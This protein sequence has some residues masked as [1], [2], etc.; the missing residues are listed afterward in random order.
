M[1][2][3]HTH[4]RIRIGIVAAVIFLT[5]A[6]VLAI[7]IINGSALP[8]RILHDIRRLSSHAREMIVPYN[9]KT[10]ELSAEAAQTVPVLVYHGIGSDDSRYSMKIAQFRNHMIALKEAGFQTASAEDFFA[11]LEGKKTLPAKSFVLTF[12]DGRKDSYYNADPILAR[13]GFSAVMFVAPG[14]S[15]VEST[16]KY[17]RYYLNPIELSR[18]M[19]TG[20]WEI[21][22]H[23]VQE[24]GGYIAIDAEGTTGQFLSNKKWLPDVLHI[25]T[26]EEYNARVS[27][28]LSQSKQSL[29]LFTGK[30]VIMF[31]YP[32]SDYGQES[33][34]ASRVAST[35][36]NA[37]VTD[38]YRYAFR[39]QWGYDSG[40]IGNRPGD[41]P[42]FL[43][44]IEPASDWTNERLLLFLEGGVDVSLEEAAHLTL[45]ESALRFRVAWGGKSAFESE[46]IT[47]QPDG[48]IASVAAILDG[49]HTWKNYQVTMDASLDTASSVA[50]YLRS[51]EPGEGVRCRFSSDAVYIETVK[52]DVATY[53]KQYSLQEEV[54]KNRRLSASI[55]GNTVGCFEEGVLVA[56]GNIPNVLPIGGTGIEYWAYN[57]RA[58][59]EISSLSIVPSA[60]M[61]DSLVSQFESLSDKSLVRVVPTAELKDALIAESPRTFRYAGENLINMETFV[62]GGS[63]TYG[64]ISGTTANIILARQAAAGGFWFWSPLSVAPHQEYAIEASYESTIESELMVRYGT[65]SGTVWKSIRM[66]PAGS[67]SYQ[68]VIEIPEG[69]QT[70]EVLQVIR[71][72]GS[73]AVIHPSIRLLQ[74]GKFARGMV[75][76]SFDDGYKSFMTNALPVLSE[77]K[78]PST[79]SIITSHVGYSRYLSAQDINSISRKGHE[80]A[81]HTRTHTHLSE[82]QEES[83]ITEIV[84]SWYDL[85][86]AG[87]K[88]TSFV[89]PYGNFSLDAKNIAARKFSGARTVSRGFNTKNTD[90]Y[91]LKDQLVTRD[92]SV[93][94]VQ[95][96][97]ATA[98]AN[99]SWLILELH[100]VLKEDSQNDSESITIAKLREILKA[101]QDSGVEVVTL[102]EGIRQLKER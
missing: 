33:L 99:Q 19:K 7:H 92:I 43:K 70:M 68:E 53:R 58:P 24:N 4:K 27:Y 50:L 51:Q 44:R 40:Y 100:E 42:L 26:D 49:T 22:S 1:H 79:V 74:S 98:N 80:I 30:P 93:V 78:M 73:L 39:Q 10:P 90:P 83:L 75:T 14:Q 32:F 101:V 57:N 72:S 76:L 88:I 91:L 64:E 9:I 46:K 85:S 97:L 34:N 63:A 38:N 84:G 31:S 69:A 21:G 67:F 45:A 95:E 6:V 17:S 23:G 3:V 102:E 41:N 13:L 62:R 37:A 48:N 82:N 12:D 66:L 55:F 86:K 35:A 2:S 87:Y 52:N 25:E 5:A 16:E 89:Y 11:F 47:V 36:I 60:A 77:F 20:R 15:L 8:N 96:Y 28:E 56:A 29:E 71:D 81:A 59:L 94:A 54:G 65:Q 61:N 18:L